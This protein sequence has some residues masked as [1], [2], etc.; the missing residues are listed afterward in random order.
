[1]P[2]AASPASP[3]SR[4]MTQAV[5]DYFSRH[6]GREL[7][8]GSQISL[9]SAQA[10]AVLSWMRRSGVDFS[11]SRLL[12]KLF[13]VEQLLGEPAAA[14]PGRGPPPEAQR[15]RAGN[16]GAFAGVGID[17]EAVSSMPIC[18]AFR[19]H[20]DRKSTRMTSIP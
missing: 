9:T 6:A 1:M 16:D 15:L 5:F 12:S 18:D 13:T 8:R 4:S 19:E 20:P 17:I 10:G 7:T 11:E 14:E 3:E 2:C